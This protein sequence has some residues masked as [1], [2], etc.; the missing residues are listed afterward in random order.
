M[1]QRLI[2]KCGIPIFKCP[3]YVF[4][5]LSCEIKGYTCI[6]LSFIPIISYIPP[7]AFRN[8]YHIAHIYLGAYYSPTVPCI[9]MGLVLSRAQSLQLVYIAGN[10]TYATVGQQISV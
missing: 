8:S 7:Y 2:S 1:H 5:S 4:M 10:E 6:S 3:P 9:T